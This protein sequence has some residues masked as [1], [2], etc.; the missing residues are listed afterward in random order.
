[1]KIAEKSLIKSLCGKI[2]HQLVILCLLS[3]L[4]L[5]APSFLFSFSA[6]ASGLLTS[7]I[8]EPEKLELTAGKTIIL[9]SKKPIK[10]VFVADQDI[11][12]ADVFSPREIVLTGKASGITTLSLWQQDKGVVGIYTL[13][14]SYDLARL[15]QKLHSMFPQEKDLRVIATHNSITLSGKVS[16]ATNLAEVVSV[17][18]AY[19]PEGKVNNLVEVGGVHQ[20]MLEVRVAEMSKGLRRDLGINLNY[21]NDNDFGVTTLG[22]LSQIIDPGSGD[23]VVQP[24]MVSAPDDYRDFSEEGGPFGMIVSETVNALFRFH[25]GGA[26]WTGFI[27]ALK[28]EGLVKV[29]AEPTLIA[30]SGQSANFLA[31]GEFPIPVPQ[32]EGSITITYKQYGVGLTFTPIVLKD[33]KI[34]IKV[35]PEVSELDFANALRYSGGVVPAISTRRAATTVELADG[36]SFAIAGLLKENVQDNISKYPL[37]GDIPILGHL[38]RSRQFQKGNSELVIVV[39]P[40][41]VKPIDAAEQTLPTDY[42]N[43]PSDAEFYILGLMQGRDKRASSLQGDLDGDFGHAMPE[44]N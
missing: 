43:E 17:A 27:D 32:E 28:G 2:K 42:Y 34:N 37:L 30:L 21:I 6:N 13:E 33:D 38:F 19:A 29:L 23:L 22:G 40:R 31:G 36:Q 15:K 18:K 5:L 26:S 24:T 16:E 7:E 25:K 44:M 12:K 9:R 3:S 14:V 20:V 35:A 11:A 41:L 1:M 39:T 10:R 4:I 8:R